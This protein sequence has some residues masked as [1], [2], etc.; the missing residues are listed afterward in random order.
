MAWNCE[1]VMERVASGGYMSDYFTK[2][3]LVCKFQGPG[4]VYFQTRNPAAFA[5][6]LRGIAAAK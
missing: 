4:T 6:N 5:A 1:Y 2:E 3:G